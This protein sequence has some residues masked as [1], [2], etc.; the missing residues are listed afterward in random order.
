MI[1]VVISFERKKEDYKQ[2]SKNRGNK[3]F[4]Y[5]SRL[6]IVTIIE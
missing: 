6:F 2:I 4:S 1:A 3:K 5:F